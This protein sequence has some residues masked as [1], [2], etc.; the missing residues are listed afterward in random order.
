MHKLTLAGLGL[1]AGAVLL[2]GSAWAGGAPVAP[3]CAVGVYTNA[4]EFFFDSDGNGIFGGIATDIRF[5]LAPALGVGTPLVGD[6][7]GNGSQAVGKF[8]PATGKFA[9][10]LNENDSWDGNAGGDRVEFF[11]AAFT[12]G[13]GFL[14][15]WNQLMN[16]SVGRYVNN[17]FFLDDNGNGIWDGIPSDARFTF[18]PSLTV[19]DTQ[20]VLGDWTGSGATD[21]AKYDTTTGRFFGDLNGNRVWDGNAGGDINSPFAA[22]FATSNGGGVIVVGDWD[23]DGDDNIALYVPSADLIFVDV[24]GN[25]VWD[26]VGGGDAQFRLAP[27]LAGTNTV[28]ACNFNDSVAGDELNKYNFETTQNATDVNGDFLFELLA[29]DTVGTFVLPLQASVLNPLVREP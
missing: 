21:V 28:N 14:G 15:E 11:V 2:D 4:D 25:F 20:I 10:D 26:G 29:N 13:V 18:I 19:P 8:I 16:D 17:E 22:A 6:F 24:N 5:R 7:V 23:G 12:G 3:S 1:I 9:L 27:A